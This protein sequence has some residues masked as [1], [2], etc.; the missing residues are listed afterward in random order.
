[1]SKTTIFLF[2]DH[3]SD[4]AL[5]AFIKWLITE[6]IFIVLR[7]LFYVTDHAK[8][9]NQYV[10]N[11]VQNTK[12]HCFSKLSWYMFWAIW[13]FFLK[14]TEFYIVF[15]NYQ[16]LLLISILVFK[17][18]LVHISAIYVRK[19]STSGFQTGVLQLHCLFPTCPFLTWYGHLL[20]L[21]GNTSIWHQ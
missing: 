3:G 21:N 15:L 10:S 20:H 6:I 19:L 11:A 9:K 18:T 7:W 1:M 8:Y 2:S 16:L 13:I 12:Y 4:N 17:L 5:H 14:I